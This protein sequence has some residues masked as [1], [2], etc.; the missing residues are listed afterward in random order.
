MRGDREAGRAEREADKDHGEWGEQREWRL[1]QAEGEH[2][3]KEGGGVNDAAQVRPE[4][5]A[6]GEVAHTNWCGENCVVDLA[7]LQLVED[8]EGGVEDGAIHGGTREECGGN[9]GRIGNFDTAVRNGA[10]HTAHAVADPEQEE[11]RF[12]EASDDDQPLSAIDEDVSLEDAKGARGE[13]G[14]HFSILL[15]KR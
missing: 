15:R 8:V 14:D 11:E 2:H 7:V 3:H 9:E 12:K 5:L 6:N 1:H 10:N 4:Q 13:A